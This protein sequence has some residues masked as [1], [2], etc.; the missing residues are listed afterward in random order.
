ML[1]CV[2]IR[3]SFWFEGIATGG[4][5]TR[6]TTTQVIKASITTEGTSSKG[7]TGSS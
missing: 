3:G 1:V 7:A 2:R 6:F 5:L 4:A